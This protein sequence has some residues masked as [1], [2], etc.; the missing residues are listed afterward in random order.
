MPE[1][2]NK[3]NPGT[4]EPTAEEIIA[5]AK[6]D[7]EQLLA[8]ARAESDAAKAESDA[9]KA[10]AERLLVEAKEKAAKIEADA[11]AKA[12][13]SAS[14]APVSSSEPSPDD[15]VPV[16]IPLGHHKNGETLFVGIN[17]TNWRIM[18]GETVNV[19]RYV[20]DYIAHQQAEA[21]AAASLIAGMQTPD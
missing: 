3:N 12:D 19:P 6:A 4:P 7:A 16:R 10:E 14:K 2:V 13:K 21:E 11:K 18:Y 5:T 9:A 20:A 17:G 15:L 8:E 1:T